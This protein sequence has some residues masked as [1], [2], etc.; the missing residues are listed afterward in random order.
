LSPAHIFVPYPFPS[1]FP[2]CNLLFVQVTLHTHTILERKNSEKIIDLLKSLG[3][4]TRE[5]QISKQYQ[6][7]FADGASSFPSGKLKRE[8]INQ[9][10]HFGEELTMI[11][12]GFGGCCC[13]M[14]FLFF[15]AEETVG[16]K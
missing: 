14:E 9:N 11:R 3:E 2:F 6:H 7:G 8:K 1:N 13:S 10:I 5:Q 12:R 15:I 4:K 16:L